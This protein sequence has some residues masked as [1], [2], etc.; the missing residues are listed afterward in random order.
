METIFSDN[1]ELPKVCFICQSPAR[2]T[3]DEALMGA[4]VVS[5]RKYDVA[6][7][8]TPQNLSLIHIEI[9][10]CSFLQFLVNWIVKY[11]YEKDDLLTEPNEM[12]GPLLSEAGNDTLP[13]DIA[14]S[15]TRIKHVLETS[16]WKVS[17]L[18]W[19]RIFL[20]IQIITYT[21]TYLRVNKRG[22]NRWQI[23]FK[24]TP[25]LYA[26]DGRVNH[27]GGGSVV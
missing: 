15:F 6:H 21:Y 24:F 9:Y 26:D 5:H 27:T 25:V 3:T 22:T 18:C 14:C 10:I 7:S 4:I 2:Q 23:Q 17:L 8:L 19:F 16:H 13:C 12:R 20:D 11:I 1:N